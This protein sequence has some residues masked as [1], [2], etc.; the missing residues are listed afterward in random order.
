M[1][2]NGHWQTG[3]SRGLTESPAELSYYISFLSCVKSAFFIPFQVK[4]CKFPYLSDGS[5]NCRDEFEQLYLT[6]PGLTRSYLLLSLHISGVLNIMKVLRHQR[7]V[8]MS[9]ITTTRN[10]VITHPAM[11]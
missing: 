2:N 5:Q 9:R 10:V 3:L 4:L 1:E 7:W 6:W 11:L 8:Y